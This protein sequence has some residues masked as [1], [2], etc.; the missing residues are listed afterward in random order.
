MRLS[1]GGVSLTFCVS[2]G[3]NRS[4]SEHLDEDRVTCLGCFLVVLSPL[5]WVCDRPDIVVPAD[6]IAEDL[7]FEIWLL[8]FRN[9]LSRRT[10]KVQAFSLPDDNGLSSLSSVS[11]PERRTTSG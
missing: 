5:F 3:S 6:G 4:F 7:R 2:V 10:G 9:R 11:E 8:R 1:V